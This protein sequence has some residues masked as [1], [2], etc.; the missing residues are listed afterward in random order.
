[1]T[2]VVNPPFAMMDGIFALERLISPM[3][4]PWEWYRYTVYLH[5]KG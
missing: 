1:M 5:G 4:D 2:L 3:T